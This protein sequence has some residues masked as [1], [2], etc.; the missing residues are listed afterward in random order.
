MLLRPILLTGIAY[1]GLGAYNH[2]MTMQ[3]SLL[4]ADAVM[5]RGLHDMISLG[6]ES[7]DD[8]TAAV[9]TDM[10]VAF[11]PSL[12]WVDYRVCRGVVFLVLWFIHY[13]LRQ[14]VNY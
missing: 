10:M 12:E 14:R 13:N 3:A 5:C 9:A 1:R 2:L 8:A 6:C 11:H 4:H 7:L